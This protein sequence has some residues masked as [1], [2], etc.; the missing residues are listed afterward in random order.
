MSKNTLKTFSG[1]DKAQFRLRQ[2]SD[3]H[4]VRRQRLLL[5]SVEPCTEGIRR[6][7]TT[8]KEQRAVPGERGPAQGTETSSASLSFLLHLPVKHLDNAV[9][10]QQTFINSDSYVH[11]QFLQK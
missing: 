10:T 4:T 8:P 9:M 7:T 1:G 2:I 5:Q 6:A 11:K 3:M